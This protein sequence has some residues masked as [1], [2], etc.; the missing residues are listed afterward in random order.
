MDYKEDNSKRAVR[1]FFI[2]T[3]RNSCRCHLVWDMTFKGKDK[4]WYRNLKRSTNNRL[5]QEILK[6]ISNFTCE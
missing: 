6:E 5:R 2:T 4:R 3:I 1:R